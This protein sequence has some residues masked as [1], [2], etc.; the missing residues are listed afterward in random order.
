MRSVSHVEAELRDTDRRREQ[1]AH[2]HREMAHSS[3]FFFLPYCLTRGILV[4]QPGTEPRPSAVKVQSPNHWTARG[5][6]LNRWFWLV[7][8]KTEFILRTKKK[9]E[10][11]RAQWCRATGEEFRF[12]QVHCRLCLWQKNKEHP[13]SHTSSC[14]IS[15]SLCPNSLF[16]RIPHDFALE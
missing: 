2:S 13:F 14:S 16:C 5:L 10:K 9:L 3:F 8:P 1:T 6:P 11:Q 12:D 4:P 7:R 15:W